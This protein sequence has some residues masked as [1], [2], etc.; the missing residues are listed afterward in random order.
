LT[1]LPA[2]P[3]PRG[4][5]QSRID[6]M[7]S[8]NTA[9]R[10][11]LGIG[12]VLLAV[13]GTTL[14]TCAGC[15]AAFVREP[16]TRSAPVSTPSSAL[17]TPAEDASFRRVR[18]QGMMD[19]VVASKGLSRNHAALEHRVRNF[20]SLRHPDTGFCWILVWSRE[21]LVP[22]ICRCRIGKRMPWWLHTIGIQIQG[23]TA[24]SLFAMASATTIRE[25]VVPR[26]TLPA[27][28][29]TTQ[30][31]EPLPL[32]QIPQTLVDQPGGQASCS[33]DALRRVTARSGPS[34]RGL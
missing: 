31:L 17:M 6:S 23:T 22:K 30:S 10:V 20:C 12:C 32:P 33:P 24:S 1:L 13:V 16:A 3:E 14:V 18:S 8:L 15:M 5:V 11:F 21:S 28:R 2:L 34:L 9:A 7:A 4:R 26:P 19:F 29:A 25:S 27:I